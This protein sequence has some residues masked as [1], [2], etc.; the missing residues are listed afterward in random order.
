MREFSPAASPG[1]ARGEMPVPATGRDGVGAG[2]VASTN[3]EFART[4]LFLSSMSCVRHTDA[5]C[6]SL[7]TRMKTTKQ[8][9]ARV[10]HRSPASRRAT[11]VASS[12]N[13]PSPPLPS[14]VVP[15]GQV[16]VRS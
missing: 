15:H 2:P 1:E 3:V 7:T 14:A 10:S 5:G 13:A 9:A 11:G 16:P 6:N 12:R 8:K 4:T